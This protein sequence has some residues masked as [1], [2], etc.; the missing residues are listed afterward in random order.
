LKCP[1]GGPDSYRDG[2]LAFI[3]RQA[4][5]NQTPTSLN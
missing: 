4:R 1:G 2:R 5:W 3:G